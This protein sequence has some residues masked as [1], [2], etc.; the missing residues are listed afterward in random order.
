MWVRRP[1]SGVRKSHL[2]ARY[3][4]E[5]S[6]EIN[7]KKVARCAEGTQ[8]FHAFAKI[9]RERSKLFFAVGIHRYVAQ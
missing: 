3:H 5:V 9:I 2:H 4:F 6:A 1:W 7:C 8:K